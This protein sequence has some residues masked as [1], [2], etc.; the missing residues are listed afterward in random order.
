LANRPPQTPGRT[1]VTWLTRGGDGCKHLKY[2]VAAAFWPCGTCDHQRSG[3]VALRDKTVS[4]LGATR[5]ESCPPTRG[6]DQ[7]CNQA[8][9]AGPHRR[10]KCPFRP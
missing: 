9:S 10:S 4:F 8:A 7:W 3:L 1:P 5:P 6:R 2:A